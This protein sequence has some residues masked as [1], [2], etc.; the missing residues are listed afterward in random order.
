MAKMPGN[1]ICLIISNLQFSALFFNWQKLQLK[2]V[3]EV[4]IPL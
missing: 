3:F 1:L 2:V 4:K